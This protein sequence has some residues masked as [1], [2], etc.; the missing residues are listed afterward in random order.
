MG[1]I[2]Y[3]DVHQWLV[4]TTTPEK[5]DA[6]IAALGKIAA[7]KPATVIAS[8]KRPGAVD[9]INN[10]HA[11]IDYIR[12]FGELKEECKDAAELFQAMVKCYPN[13]VNRV[14]LWLGCQANY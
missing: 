11:T 4:E 5:R 1:D 9:G 3:N 12:K 6:W 13:R 8:H 10:V 2:C 7:L 14:I